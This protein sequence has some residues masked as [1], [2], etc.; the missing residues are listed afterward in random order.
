MAMTENKAR[1]GQNIPVQNNTKGGP[2]QS[3]PAVRSLNSGTG[4]YS[5]HRSGKDTPVHGG[6]THSYNEAGAQKIL[7]K[8]HK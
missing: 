2:N 6:Q 4:G 8:L 7:N 3:A 5:A 1:G